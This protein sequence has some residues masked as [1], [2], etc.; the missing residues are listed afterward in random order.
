M[1][2]HAPYEYLETL[3]KGGTLQEVLTAIC[4]A[5]EPTESGVTSCILLLDE[6]GR[7]F[8]VGGGS[9]APAE[10]VNSL[11]GAASGG[12][13][14]AFAEAVRSGTLAATPD[15]KGDAAWGISGDIA[16]KNQIRA[17]SAQPIVGADGS[18]L[19]AVGFFF[20]KKHLPSED[21]IA[22][23]KAAANAAARVIERT[24][25][26]SSANPHATAMQASIDAMSVVSDAGEL[27]FVNEIQASILGH[28]SPADLVGKNWRAIFDDR[29]I[30]EIEDEVLPVV[31]MG[32][33][34]HGEA[35]ALRQDGTRFK[36]DISLAAA[37]NGRF[38][39]VSRDP[40][41]RGRLLD[42]AAD[43]ERRLDAVVDL[44]G[45]WRWEIDGDYQFTFVSDRYFEL[46]GAGRDVVIGARFH[47]LP[48]DNPGAEWAELLE[49]LDAK[50]PFHD[51]I[52][53]RRDS[54]GKTLWI[55]INGEPILDD[56]GSFIGYHG[57]SRNVTDE[58][59]ARKS[60]ESNAALFRQL[61]EKSFDATIVSEDGRIVDAN[62]AA[63]TLFGYPIFDLA[64]KDVAALLAPGPAP[65]PDTDGIFESE[66]VRGDGTTFP[67]EVSIETVTRDGIDVRVIAVRDLSSNKAAESALRDSEETARA[68]IDATTDLSALLDRDLAILA[69]NEAFAQNVGKTTAEIVGLNVYDLVSEESRD[70]RRAKCREAL[71][72]GQP[73]QYESQVGDKW[74]FSSYRPVLGPD[75]TAQKIAVFV[76]DITESKRSEQ[77]LRE[78][79]ERYRTLIEISPDAIYVHKQGRIVLANAA[80]TRLFGAEDDQQLIGITALDLIHP[81]DRDMVR[82]RYSQSVS[83]RD[84]LTLDEQKRL[85]LDGTPFV[86]EVTVTPLVWDG[87]P[88]GLAIIRDVTEKKAQEEA[89]RR[90]ESQLTLALRAARLGFWE[91]D[92]DRKE[93]IWSDEARAIFGIDQPGFGSGYEDF[94]QI[95]H[96]DD[97]EMVRA[98]LSRTMEERLPFSVRHRV[99]RPDGTQICVQ[100]DTEVEF[101]DTGRLVRLAGAVQDVTELWRAEQTTLENEHRLRSISD[102]VP[103]MIYQ[104]LM[105]PDGR[106]EYPYLNDGVEDVT[107]FDRKTLM[108]NPTLLMDLVHP[109]DQDGFRIALERSAATL[110][111]MTIDFRI[112]TK[113]GEQKWVR[114]KS[115][116][117]GRDDGAI[118]WDSMVFDI[119]DRKTAEIALAES[120][121]RLNRHL[122]ELQVTKERLEARTAELMHTAEE[123]ERSRD[124]AETANRAKSEF[125]ATMSHEIRTPMNGV[126]GMTGL[127]LDTELTDLQREYVETIR[128]CGDALLTIINDILDFSKME[129][130]KLELEHAEF[131]LGEL[132]ENI[133]HLIGRDAVD[134]GLDFP[135]Y[136]SPD[137][138]Y[139]LVGD[140]G[141]LRQVLMNLIGNGIKFTEEGAV[142][143]EVNVE[144]ED[145]SSVLLRFDVTDTGIGDFRRRPAA[146]FQEVQPGRRIDNT[147][148]RWDGLGSRHLQTAVDDDGRRHRRPQ[149]RGGRKHVFRHRTARAGRTTG[150]TRSSRCSNG[151]AGAVHWWS[152]TAM[153]ACA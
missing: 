17:C 141:R 85:K 76:H 87:E 124:A 126:L 23:L 65:R 41:E 25:A 118:L 42:A 111:P 132:V 115:R 92:L 74:Y 22:R 75:G 3:S 145:E 66:G 99:N 46:T 144:S 139:M 135:I 151:S 133:A 150:Q 130:G 146:A 53:A 71:E 101:D 50:Q 67:I 137:V 59:A 107:G 49:T 104:R 6:T 103:G 20:R 129:A 131:R 127:V 9:S 138:P 140:S 55:S 123:L 94:L 72:T 62:A 5:A 10:L 47:D 28:D 84:A 79:E 142:S 89:Q 106:I 21:E 39:C 29:E 44:A 63:S 121:A 32:G 7:R 114:V 108:A 31:L 60:L 43:A 93:F 34:W 83:E 128:D 1:R 122:L 19:G 14:G 95:V 77:V 149:P 88:G 12:E 125:L 112:E 70:L 102:N 90:R 80:A 35:T 81:D 33:T 147:T 36:T 11:N 105:H 98:S 54:A 30:S 109:H 18:I 82:K 68:M 96:P 2:P 38:L 40:T 148:I 116:P 45:A 64:G 78:S 91:W 52:C 13:T 120:E 24:N 117:R 86:A 152:T 4:A 153:P 119:T 61:A 16:I 69:A 58:V 110:E 56:D 8:G 113:D 73:V 27:L 15:I 136:V 134:K 143:I 48:P 57:M 100:V 97:M 51:F 37:E 26:T